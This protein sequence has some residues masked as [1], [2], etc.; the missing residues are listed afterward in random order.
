METP[1]LVLVLAPDREVA[2]AVFRR[3]ASV[4]ADEGCDVHRAP[5]GKDALSLVQSTAFDLVVV[6]LPLGE[7]PLKE[8]VRS[9][10]WRAS[11]CRHA[12]VLVVGD[13]PLLPDARELAPRGINR[14]V[15]LDAPE[16]ELAG[17]TRELLAVAPRAP[18]KTMVRLEARGARGL[19]RAVAQTDN[20]SRTGML[21]RGSQSYSQGTGL[22]FEL[23]LPR[24]P[25]PLQGEAEVVRVTSPETESVRGYAMRFVA[26]EGDGRQRLER[27]LRSQ[28][29]SE[30]SGPGS[31]TG[32][33]A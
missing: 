24:D 19:E 11:A 12:S 13:R 7:L 28:L 26:V 16:E 18:L 32:G 30:G 10:R 3:F 8:V 17:A 33:A 29:E 14:L 20:L 25:L 4:F 27:F 2:A 31:A 15:A 22:H 9:V 1:R 21:V 5:T 6:G 23:M